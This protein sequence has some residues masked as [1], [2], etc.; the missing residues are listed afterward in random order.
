MRV[1]IKYKNWKG[2]TSTRDIMPH[3]IFFGN[4]EYHKDKQWILTAWD[5]G[6]GDLRT[7]A[8]KDIKSW[9]EIT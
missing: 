1:S 8:M 4:N 6:K 5:I 9:G 7:F 2:V 3:S